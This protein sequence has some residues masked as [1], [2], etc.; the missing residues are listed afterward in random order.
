MSVSC[1]LDIP[2]GRKWEHMQNPVSYLPSI[3]VSPP[4]A[5]VI[6]NMSQKKHTSLL[7]FTLPAS[8]VHVFRMPEGTSQSPAFNICVYKLLS[9][10]LPSLYKAIGWKY[11]WQGYWFIRY[12]GCCGYAYSWNEE[13]S[14][15]LVN[16]WHCIHLLC[17][18]RPDLTVGLTEVSDTLH[19]F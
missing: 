5:T 6:R 19:L 2:A 8:T 12:C 10:N 15:N 11:C 1:T 4:T 9:L 13:C 16:E 18:L 7:T 17:K 14:W 3:P